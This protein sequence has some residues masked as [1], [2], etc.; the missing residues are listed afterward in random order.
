MNGSGSKKLNR[1]NLG[2]K[3]SA[4]RRGYLLESD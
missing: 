4:L 1:N 2:L 3:L